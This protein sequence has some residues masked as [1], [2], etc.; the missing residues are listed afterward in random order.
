MHHAGY[1]KCPLVVLKQLLKKTSYYHPKPHA[2]FT[3]S[4]PPSL[5][6]PH[7]MCWS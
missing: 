2:Q 5:V 1:C 6:P 3:S 4:P 7:R